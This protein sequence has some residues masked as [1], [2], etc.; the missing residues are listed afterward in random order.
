MKKIKQKINFNGIKTVSLKKRNSKVTVEDSAKVTGKGD[1]F[2]AFLASLPRILAAEDFKSVVAAMQTARRNRKKILIMMGAH[3]VKCGLN[4]LLIDLMDKGFIS[5]IAMNGATAIHD[6][7]LAFCGKTSEDVSASIQ[8]GSFGMSKETSDFFNLAMKTAA[9]KNAGLGEVAGAMILKQR[10]PYAGYSLQANAAR[11]GIPVTIHVAIGTDI[12]HPHPGCNG[13]YLGKASMN[14]FQRFTAL[15]SQL[16]NGVALNIGSAVIMP[17]VFLKAVSAA[18]N[19]GYRVDN[20]TAV[21]MDMIRHYRPFQN[22]VSRPT[23]GSGK[24]YY[25]IGHHEI[26]LPLLHRALVEAI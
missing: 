8:D 24:G 11:L 22:V 17:E 1:S 7:E 4:P 13:A 21:C 26:M 9:R 12:I 10:L 15:V 18:R 25:L 20:F 19:L 16:E 3:A 14:D 6:F 5:G 23:A 2:S